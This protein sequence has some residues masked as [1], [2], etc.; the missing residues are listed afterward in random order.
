MEGRSLPG[1]IKKRGGRQSSPASF[2][3]IIL[4][5][6]PVGS[7]SRSAWVT[8][9]LSSFSSRSLYTSP[10]KPKAEQP[11]GQ[12]PTKLFFKMPPDWPVALVV[13]SKPALQ[14][15]GDSLRNTRQPKREPKQT[16][17]TG[18]LPVS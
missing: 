18:F 5:S 17:G 13:F 9:A 8:S 2:T 16:N 4:V 12:I 15:R 11:A 10:R 7:I 3:G 6:R 14:V 1:S